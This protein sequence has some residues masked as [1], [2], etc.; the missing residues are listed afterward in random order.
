MCIYVSMRARA[1]EYLAFVLAHPFSAIILYLSCHD[2]FNTGLYNV[3]AQSLR[4]TYVKFLEIMAVYYLAKYRYFLISLRRVA[5]ADCP[6]PVIR[7]WALWS[8]VPFEN[9]PWG[10]VATFGTYPRVP[11][12]KHYVLIR[13]RLKPSKI[14]QIRIISTPLI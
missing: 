8:Y 7:R 2:E 1:R 10:G 13:K 5:H 12:T 3:S 6:V 9:G 14:V 4:F 11:T